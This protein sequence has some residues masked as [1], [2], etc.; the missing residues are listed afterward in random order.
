M[1]IRLIV[2]SSVRNTL[3][4]QWNLALRQ[5]KI[6][7]A[8]HDMLVRQGRRPMSASKAKDTNGVF[9]SEDKTLRGELE[10]LAAT[11]EQAAKGEGAEALKAAAGAARRLADQADKGQAELEQLIRQRPLTAVAV[12]GVAGFL[13]ALLVRR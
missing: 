12:A 3:V 11:I 7:G 6:A 8:G 9:G 13:L 5:V 10:R 1:R 2:G 4:E